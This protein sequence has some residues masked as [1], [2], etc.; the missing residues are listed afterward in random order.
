MRLLKFLGDHLRQFWKL[1]AAAAGTVVLI[2]GIYTPLKEAVGRWMLRQVVSRAGTSSGRVV[3]SDFAAIL[4]ASGII[5]LSLVAVAL[6]YTLYSLYQVRR[7]EKTGERRAGTLEKT[8]HRTQQAADKIWNRLF[9]GPSRPLKKVIKLRQVWTIY[10]N[11]D[12]NFVETITLTTK[13]KD[14]HFM[15]K[16]VDVEQLAEPAEFPDDIDLKIKPGGN[17]EIAYLISKNEPRSKH[18]IV[19]F[20]PFISAGGRDEREL[21]V[22]Y[23][24]KGLFRGLLV[25]GEEPFVYREGSADPIPEVEYQFWI[26]PKMGSL[27]CTNT[28]VNLGKDIHGRDVER[29]EPSSNLMGMSGWIYSAR[30]LP[31]NHTT[32][33]LLEL[34]RT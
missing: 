6:C 28:G 15:W 31:G 32:S 25:K 20:L 34:R 26:K 10:E 19:F 12:C 8:F 30:D 9:L 2:I 18:F 27:N 16:G 7:A 11:G 21:T 5:T 24:W 33:L 14:I 23:Y 22:S 4:I 29:L 17:G 13:D 1:W 3:V